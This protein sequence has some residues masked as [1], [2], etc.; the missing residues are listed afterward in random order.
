MESGSDGYAERINV[1]ATERAFFEAEL[2]S[3]LEKHSGEFVLIKGTTVIGFYADA[4]EAYGA[5]QERFGFAP[6]FLARVDRSLQAATAEAA[7]A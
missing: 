6:F 5:G 2:N 1:L 3:M 4:M 7:V